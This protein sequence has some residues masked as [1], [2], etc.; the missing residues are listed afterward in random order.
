MGYPYLRESAYLS[1]IYPNIF[2][3]LSLAIPFAVSEIPAMLLQLLGLAPTSKLL[4]ASDGFSVPELFWLG[5]Q[6][7]RTALGRVL[8]QLVA[9]N[10]LTKGKAYA[11]AEQILYRN[12]ET[13]YN[14]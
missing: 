2:V 10:I 5:A 9:D 3:D 7:C 4:Y 6:A 14:L 12:S 13:L 1:S 8:D 11:S